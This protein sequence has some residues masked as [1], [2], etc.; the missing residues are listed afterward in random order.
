M[1]TELLFMG[2]KRKALILKQLLLYYTKKLL[3]KGRIK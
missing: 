2:F 3:K 1:R